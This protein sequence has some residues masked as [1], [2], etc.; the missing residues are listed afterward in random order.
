MNITKSTLWADF[1]P[2]AT[3]ERMA[4]LREKITDCAVFDFWKLTIGDFAEL[5]TI[6]FID[7]M[8]DLRTVEDVIMFLNASDK[9]LEDFAN[10]MKNFEVPM[11]NEEKEA[12][13]SLPEFSP[14]ESM[15]SFCLEKFGQHPTKGGYNEEITLQ[16]FRIARKRAYS[17]ALFQRKLSEIQIRKS[18]HK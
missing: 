6:G 9:F 16:E 2:F 17:D 12:S 13:A 8:K 14:I 10:M 5:I 18:K 15:L 1:A 4:Q 11:T 7:E 3:P